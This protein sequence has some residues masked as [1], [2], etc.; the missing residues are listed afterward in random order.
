MDINYQNN[1]DSETALLVVASSG[2]RGLYLIKLILEDS[3]TDPNTID[4]LGKTAI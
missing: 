2:D 3:R 1:K 4:K